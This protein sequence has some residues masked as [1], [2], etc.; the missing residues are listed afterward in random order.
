MKIEQID[1]NLIK[2]YAKNPRKNDGAVEKVAQSIKEFGF[3]QPI[4]VDKN[5]VIVVGHTRYKAAT[6]LKL[7]NVPVVVADISEDK[8]QAYRLA[9]NKLNELA[10]WDADLLFE[11]MGSIV[12]KG[13]E[14][15]TGFNKQ[16]INDILDLADDT[17][18]TKKVDTPIYTPKGELPLLKELYNEDRT[19]ELVAK[20]KNADIEE[21]IKDFLLKA[22]HRHRVFD[23]ENIA[24]YYSH[25]QAE[26]KQLMED[27]A[28]VIIDFD[29][30]IELGY[31]N[32]TK[33][34]K[35]NY[36]D[37]YKENI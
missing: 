7:T 21:D 27:L 22:A 13:N 34:L 15:L 32:L 30:A 4:V 26:V 8:L 2:P 12:A 18:Y 33:D 3:Q 24:E 36:Q 29:R 10:D 14:Q 6:H 23:Y 17:I 1:I 28:L 11:E 19:A 25:Q 20:I 31:V 35:Q 16:E 9:D 5:M 37:D